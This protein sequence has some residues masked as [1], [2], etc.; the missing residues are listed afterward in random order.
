M[1]KMKLCP[2]SFEPNY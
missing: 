2:F 1:K